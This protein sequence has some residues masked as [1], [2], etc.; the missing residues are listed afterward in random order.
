MKNVPFLIVACVVAV[1][2]ELGIG[3]G[4]AQTPPH[5]E[6]SVRRQANPFG[7]SSLSAAV[8]QATGPST[9][10]RWRQQPNLPQPPV[11]KH[12]WIKRHRAAFGALV[13]F[14][15][16]FLIGYLPGDDGVFDDFTAEFNGLVL[17]GVGALAGAVVAE[18]TH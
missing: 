9:I 11:Q 5:Q 18:A 13:G 10:A 3:I 1:S 7:M 8:A 14:G 4:R 6:A 16:G 2:A 17:G 15:S 12:N